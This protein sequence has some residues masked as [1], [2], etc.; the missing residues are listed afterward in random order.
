MTNLQHEIGEKF[1]DELS[2]SKQV[3]PEM[4]ASLRELLG[5]GKKL[6][7]DDF[8]RIFSKPPSGVPK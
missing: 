2:K 8:V 4:I 5:T 1:L 7:A 3:D 6:K